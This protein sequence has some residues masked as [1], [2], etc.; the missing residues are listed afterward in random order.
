MSLKLKNV[1]TR[2]VSYVRESQLATVTFIFLN[3]LMTV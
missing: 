1:K 2:T 3:S